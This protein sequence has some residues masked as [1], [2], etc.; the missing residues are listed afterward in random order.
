MKTALLVS[1]VAIAATAGHAAVRFTDADV[2]GSADVAFN[3]ISDTVFFSDI[4]SAIFDD[5]FASAGTDSGIVDALGSAVSFAMASAVVNTARAVA[6]SVLINFLGEVALSN[7][8]DEVT[9]ASSSVSLG[10]GEDT[11]FELEITED[12]EYRFRTEVIEATGTPL[13]GARLSKVEADGLVALDDRGVLFSGDIVRI[14]HELGLFVS[15]TGEDVSESARGFAR[16]TL[17][18][19]GPVAAVVAGLAWTARRRRL[20]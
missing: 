17:P 13:F 14:D 15:S 12:S 16:L 10:G 11:F 19:P 7:L 8:A 9:S 3:S 18:A 4:G 20:G 1:A 6:P 5:N 2:S